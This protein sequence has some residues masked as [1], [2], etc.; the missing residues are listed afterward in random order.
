MVTSRFTP[1]HAVDRPELRGELDVA[2]ARPLTAVVAGAGAGKSV[3]LTQW[4]DSHPEVPVVWIDVEPAD[5][6]PGH[7]VRH[8]LEGLTDVAP[9]IVGI[10]SPE[11]LSRVGINASIAEAIVDRLRLAGDFAL[12]F[13]DIHHLADAGIVAA[14]AGLIGDLPGNVHVITSSRVDL[15]FA[16]TRARLRNEVHEI[17]QAQ[18]AL[19]VDQSAE[20]VRRITALELDDASVKALVDRTEGWP[21]GLLLAAMTLRRHPDPVAFISEFRGSD[22]LVAEYLSDE[23]LASLSEEDRTGALELSVLDRMTSSLVAEASSTPAI[24]KLLGRLQ[25]DSQFL[26]PLDNHQEWFRFHHLFRDLLR[27]RLRAEDPAAEARI[28]TNAAEWHLRRGELSTAVEYLLRAGQWER[29]TEVILAHG[30]SVFEQ[31]EMVTVL[32]WIG[33]LPEGFRSQN[34]DLILF[35]GML[36]GMS[37]HATEA[38]DLL[39]TA[40]D[41]PDST[42]G[43]TACALTFLAALVHWNPYPQASIE[44]A[45]RALAALARLGNGPTPDL[46]HLTDVHSLATVALVSGG[47]AHFLAGHFDEARDWLDRA[48]VSEG[49]FYSVWRISALGSLALLSAWA[50]YTREAVEYATEA[51]SVAEATGTFAHPATAEAFLAKALVAFEAG[52]VGRSEFELHEA[53][54]RVAANQRVQLAWVVYG[55]SALVHFAQ[56][57]KH[58]DAQ[59][60]GSPPPVVGELILA[61][62][63]RALRL[64]GAPKAAVGALSERSSHSSVLLFELAAAELSLG[65]SDEARVIQQ[66]LDELPDAEDPLPK[67]RRLLV[68]AW[69]STMFGRTARTDLLLIQALHI[70]NEHDLTTVFTDSG[71]EITTRIAALGAPSLPPIAATVLHEAAIRVRISADAGLTE[72]LTEREMELV[73]LLP[74][75]LTNTELADRF[76]V[77]VN[78]IK[79]HMAH[80]YRK[81]E[82]SNR[83]DAIERATE[84]GMMA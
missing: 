13:D 26:I 52:D 25:R 14:V 51:I 7:F 27:V 63:A 59:P 16:R 61:L 32:R 40:A 60:P 10:A 84:L 37:G 18:L 78:T 56:T 75:R 49:A 20:L 72:P 62:R 65:H 70:A 83:S 79:S 2:L 3:L 39:R 53:H 67:I 76:F 44:C 29:A 48:L 33:E 50:G 9:G 66:S 58:S 1:A 74:T 57:H 31:G 19:D 68:G 34:I 81:L 42:L 35:H 24:L 43:Q 45:E 38:E 12:I 73:A 55:L 8:L 80:I 71:P 22:R 36:A 69:L 4:A 17:R 28:L 54:T 5:A 23:V 11:T 41:H 30:S 46:L 82:V 6:D 21:A 77:S 64:D 47:R 15:P